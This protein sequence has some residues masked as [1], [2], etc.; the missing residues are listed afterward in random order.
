MKEG[1]KTKVNDKVI[2]ERKAQ[3]QKSK[4]KLRARTCAAIFVVFLKCT[5]EKGLGCFQQLWGVYI[6]FQSIH[7]KWT[8]DAIL[9]HMGFYATT[10][11]PNMMM[12]ENHTTQS[13]EYI[14]I[15]EDELY[16]VA[17]H[18]KKFCRCYKSQIQDQYLSSR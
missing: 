17:L 18:L 8:I 1:A 16:I 14:I 12:R 7:S 13:S 11:N 4:Q 5:L 3:K 6:D 15:Y 10:E 2:V 9:Q